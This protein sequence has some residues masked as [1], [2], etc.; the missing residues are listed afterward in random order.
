MYKTCEN[1]CVISGYAN[2]K[3]ASLDNTGTLEGFS[4]H[5]LFILYCGT[6]SR[7]FKR[8][9]LSFSSSQYLTVAYDFYA[10][11]IRDAACL[12]EIFTC[13]SFLFLSHTVFLT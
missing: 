9:F 5:F 13:Q 11:R 10:R 3:V 6:F 1:V 7:F 2:I 4:L 12:L 8:L